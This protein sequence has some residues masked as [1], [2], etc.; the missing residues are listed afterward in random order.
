MTGHEEA[1]TGSPSVSRGSGAQSPGEPLEA[2]ESPARAR[3]G[4]WMQVY[5]GAQF[6]PL[7]VQTQDF[8]IRDIAHSLSLQCRYNGHVDK[9]YSVA[10]HSVLVSYCVP[11]EYKLW[12]LLHDAAEAYTG[13]M[14]RP[15]KRSMLDFQLAEDRILYKLAE[16][17]NLPHTTDLVTIQDPI[18]AVVKEVD[19]RILLNERHALMKKA[20]VPWGI[21]HLEP[22]PIGI[23]SWSPEEAE[24][25]FLRVFEKYGGR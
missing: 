11:E 14:V 13:D 16:R 15:L 4:N 3:Y 12:A 5:S 19:N 24:R 9:F 1:A 10:E 22:L 8:D 25:M 7:D 6:W 2:V 23:H 18:P 17:F 21:E 20:Q